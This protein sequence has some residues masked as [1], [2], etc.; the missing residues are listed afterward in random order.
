MEL[1]VL[2]VFAGGLVLVSGVVALVLHLTTV[3]RLERRVWELTRRV[4]L[5]ER[6]LEGAATEAEVPSPVPVSPSPAPTSPAPSPPRAGPSSTGEEP[7][8][9]PIPAP[10]RSPTPAAAEIGPP[11]TAKPPGFGTRLMAWLTTGGG[12]VQV[13]VVVLFVG[14]ALFVGYAADRGWYPLE[15]RLATAALGGFVLVVVGHRLVPRR[16]I[17]GLALQGGGLAIVYV[18]VFAATVRYGML[19]APSAFVVF[20][21]IAAVAGAL[22]AAEDSRVLAHLA[23]LGAVAAPL[24]VGVGGTP[25]PLLF[26]YLL[27]VDVAV[28]SLGAWRGWTELPPLGSAGSFVVTTAWWLGNHR[29]E[30]FWEVE[31]F[32]VAILVVFVVGTVVGAARSGR[33]DRVRV[34]VIFGTPVWLF[35]YL[36]LGA[37]HLPHGLGWTALGLALL[38]GLATGVVGRARRLRPV[39]EAFGFLAVVFALVA[40][41]AFFDDRITAAIWAVAGAA[42]VWGGARDRRTWARVVGYGVLAIPN[43]TFVAGVWGE[44]GPRPLLDAAFVG[45]ILLGGTALVAGRAVARPSL[46]PVERGI[47]A[48][49]GIWAVTMGYLVGLVEIWA[50]VD[51]WPGPSLGYAAAVTAAWVAAAR[52]LEWPLLGFPAR[53]F[54]WALFG[55]AGI[56]AGTLGPPSAAGG[57]LG[58]PLA[59]ATWIWVLWD[60]ARTGDDG[61]P[62]HV[63][64]LLLGTL[65]AAWELGHR[66]AGGDAASSWRGFVHL[67]IPAIVVVLLEGLRTD[68]WPLGPHGRTYRVVGGGLVLVFAGAWAALVLAA[69]P[70]SP[71]RLAVVDP[72]DLGALVLGVAAFTWLRGRDTPEPAR[73][74]GAWIL[75]GWG[76]WMTHVTI[77]RAVHRLTGVPYE[78]EAIVGSDLFQT[79]VSIFWSGLALVLMFA[80]TRRRSRPVWLTGM[81]LLGL[82]VVKLFVVDLANVGTGWRIVSFLGVGALILTV[83]YLAPLPPDEA[84]DEEAT[85]PTE[86]LNRP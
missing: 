13:G 72:L 50:H 35:V 38:Y 82:T 46:P 3:P 78:A 52:F 9:R 84:T 59:V 39:A 77:A 49:L 83:A 34:G 75:G 33:P 15:A 48:L 16:R 64:L 40:V 18:T 55:I 80:A 36:G 61:E 11:A 76:F 73:R 2:F 37:A 30:L 41:P 29:P 25:A 26:G 24:V 71:P 65:L 62:G 4:A 43:L 66:V 12:L 6:R 19:P 56:W 63:G 67:A 51:D 45:R 86:A 53:G 44:P 58:W 85:A 20:V 17:Y 7:E 81:S 22:A 8:G 31:P 32:L 21:G 23:V 47:G 54:F 42:L 70:G 74:A 27:A 69:T 14:A 57:W 5:L 60:R 10:P 1:V 79:T 68:R 28:V